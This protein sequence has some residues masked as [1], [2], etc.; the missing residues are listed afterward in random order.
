MLKPDKFSFLSVKADYDFIFYR[1]GRSE[2]DII[3]SE[4]WLI[5]YTAISF[6]CKS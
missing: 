4:Q 3:I 6:Y 1:D 5:E 2:Y